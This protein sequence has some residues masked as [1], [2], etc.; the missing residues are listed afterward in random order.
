MPL[1]GAPW[2]VAKRARAE[3]D[4]ALAERDRALAERDVACEERDRALRERDS[5]LLEV[6]APRVA[7]A[8][9]TAAFRVRT[10][11]YQEA[12]PGAKRALVVPVRGPAANREIEIT[13]PFFEA[14]CRQVGIDLRIV[15][16]PQPVPPFL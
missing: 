11:A 15:D 4:R 8:D 9:A 12:E 10:G 1:I 5:A 16:V 7:A 13:Q 14:Y 2:R 6:G 3:R